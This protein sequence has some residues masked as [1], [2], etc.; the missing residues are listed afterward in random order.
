MSFI[1]IG[2]ILAGRRP[3]CLPRWE[4]RCRHGGRTPTAFSGPIPGKRG[5]AVP[6]LRNSAH[7][8]QSEKSPSFSQKAMNPNL[9][10][11]LA[12][13]IALA[14]PGFDGVAA[15]RQVL[16][17]TP[18]PACLAPAAWN[19]LE[20]ER[21]RVIG[22]LALLGEM[23]KRDVV[24]LGEQ[25]GEADHHRW[26][27]QVLAAFHVQ[28]PNMVIGFEMFP[29]RVQPV[30]DRWVAGELTVK[31]F[32]EQ[33][34]WS[35]VWN[36]PA[37]LY[38]PLIQFARINRIRMLALNVDKKLSHA[39]AEQG[40]DAVPP[41]EREGVSRPAAPVEAYRNLLFQEYRE[42]RAWNGKEGAKVAQSD[43]AFRHFLEAQTTW[44]RAMA[45]A[46]A[47][48]LSPGSAGDKPLVVGIMGSGHI[49]FGHGVPHQLRELGV[50]RIGTLLPLPAG[51]NCEEL[52]AG[53]ADAVF[54]LPTQAEAKPEP[55]RLGVSLEEEDGGVRIAEVTVGSLADKT[56]LKSGDRL[57]EVAGQPVKQGLA[58]T[59]AVRRQPPGTWLPVRVKRG[60]E[61]LDF[62]IKFPATP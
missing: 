62:V 42:H 3:R 7:T 10:R 17:A 12:V 43:A 29:R 23:A 46:L 52:R 30:L 6:H 39:I 35:R 49:R 54:A 22:A 15:A 14:M 61:T 34:E 31:E 2:A 11:L 41:A 33:S 47:R 55:P 53:L 45:E 40:W 20:G 28:R 50:S 9:A 51:S 16:A 37:E 13:A 25:H 18:A 1:G 26:Q 59:V 38:L 32:L 58:V 4:R 8:M 56:G 19:G 27:L 21:P 24:L 5:S 44:D 60:D 36:M 57:V 48:S